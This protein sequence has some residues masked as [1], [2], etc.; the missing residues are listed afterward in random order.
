M[1]MAIIKGQ[2]HVDG[3][4]KKK[5]GSKSSMIEGETLACRPS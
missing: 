2:F 4:K 5:R 1:C 3:K